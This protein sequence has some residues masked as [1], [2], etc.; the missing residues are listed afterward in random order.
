MFSQSNSP[1]LPNG[2]TNEL[3]CPIG[4]ELM[5]DPYMTAD[6]HSYERRNIEHWLTFSDVSPATGDRLPNK[7]LTPNHALRN[8]IQAITTPDR[9]T[10]KKEEKENSE[11][12]TASTVKESASKTLKIIIKNTDNV[13]LL[14]QE[15]LWNA[16]SEKIK[17]QQTNPLNLYVKIEQ[18]ARLAEARKLAQEGRA[19]AENMLIFLVADNITSTVY[20]K[21]AIQRNDL[22]LA[23]LL[24]WLGERNFE[25]S[26]FTLALHNSARD[27]ELASFLLAHLE[28]PNTTWFDDF[29]IPIASYGNEN[30]VAQLLH[31]APPPNEIL[32]RC[33]AAAVFEQNIATLSVILSQPCIWLQSDIFRLSA[34]SIRQAKNIT[35]LRML[36]PHLTASTDKDGQNIWSVVFQHYSDNRNSNNEFILALL[37]AGVSTADFVLSSQQTNDILTN[38]ELGISMLTTLIERDLRVSEDVFQLLIVQYARSAKEIEDAL[39]RLQNNARARQ[40]HNEPDREFSC[41]IAAGFLFMCLLIGF[42]VDLAKEQDAR[43][44]VCFSIFLV[45]CLLCCCMQAICYCMTDFIPSLYNLAVMIFSSARQELMAKY[46][47]LNKDMY[48]AIQ[49]LKTK[50]VTPTEQDIQFAHSIEL[51]HNGKFSKDI[52]AAIKHA[53]APEFVWTNYFSSCLNNLWKTASTNNRR[54]SEILLTSMA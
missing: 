35:V 30:L 44:I 36:L 10:P 15:N 1:Q 37:D 45:M 41:A 28:L 18:Q 16:A 14:E 50:N 11:N 8:V 13:W 42:T 47:T 20:L 39:Q 53:A 19:N 33:A 7:E 3:F 31:I 48:S 49:A 46:S 40:G 4:Y 2:I 5:K 34:F 43:T 26:D 23:Q 52:L 27:F 22:H 38:K 17:T 51:Y 29:Y 54:D 24:I 21:T 6:G 12:T 32:H 9:P 25:V